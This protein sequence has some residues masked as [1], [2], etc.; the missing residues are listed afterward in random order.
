DVE[1]DIGSRHG[2]GWQRA[3]DDGF[4]P[5]DIPSAV[6]DAD[7]VVVAV[8][9]EAHAQMYG[10]QIGPHLANHAT[11]GFLHG[12]SVHYG[13]VTPPDGVGVVMVAPKGPGTTLRSRFVEGLGIPCLLAVHRENHGGNAEDLAL[14]WANGIGCARAGIIY[15]SFADETEMD[16]FGEQA[17]L[18]G[19]LFEMILAAFETL[20]AEGYPPELAYIECCHEV[21][22]I[23]DLIY[24][25]GLAATSIAISNTAE[26]GAYHAGPRLIDEHVRTRLVELLADIRSGAFTRRFEAD[27]A[28]GFP[29]FEA[30]RSALAS[31]GIE[32]AG[33]VVRALMHP[34]HVA[35]DATATTTPT[36]G[37]PPAR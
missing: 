33:A 12:F 21:K 19:G 37:G 36:P 11:L 2:A 32:P 7:L 8:P 28:A 3:V 24:E 17:V 25:R 13:L 1:V 31:H 18:C 16:L 23:G 22:Q 9:D 35:K 29:W 4:E 27:H 10:E 26:F 6:T 20:E 30:R 14:A 5:R 34:D 15:T